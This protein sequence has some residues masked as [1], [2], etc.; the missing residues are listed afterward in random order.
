[1]PKLSAGFLMWKRMSGDLNVLLVHPGGPFWTKKDLGA[2]SIPKG[3][4]QAGEDALIAA[5]REFEEELG[6]AAQGAVTDL[7]DVKQKGGKVVTC[8]AI[9]SDLDVGA[10]RSNMFELEWPLRS[11]KHQLFPEVDRARWL[12]LADARAKISPAQAA[13]LDRLADAVR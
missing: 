13:L 1:V 8:F 4:P 9:E 7:G 2:W 6:A 10:I 3:E 5:R 12:S 11:G